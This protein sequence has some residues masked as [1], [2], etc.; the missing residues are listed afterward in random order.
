[1][2]VLAFD[3]SSELLCL[4]LRKG[5]LIYERFWEAGRAQVE[6]LAPAIAHILSQAELKPRDL[7]L[8]VCGQGPGSFSGLRIAMATAKGLAAGTSLP[9]VSVPSLD[10]FAKAYPDQPGYRVPIIDGHKGRLYAALYQGGLRQGQWLDLCPTDLAAQLM[11]Q[12]D[13]SLPLLFTGPN[14][15]LMLSVCEGMPLWTV[16]PGYASPRPGALTE[17]G[18]ELFMNGATDKKESCPLYVRDSEED[19]GVSQTRPQGLGGGKH[20]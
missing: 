9:L 18:M 5:Q 12:V 14:A 4:A 19:L 3:A 13:N 16:A 8:I 20:G 2:N 6:S 10:F 17:L 7:Q 15:D 11:Q 1:M